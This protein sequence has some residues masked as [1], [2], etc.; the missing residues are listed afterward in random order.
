MTGFIR[1]I[2]FRYP[3]IALLNSETPVTALLVDV[4]RG[5]VTGRFNLRSG[6]IFGAPSGYSLPT[7]MEWVPMALDL[8][9]EF[10]VVCLHAAVVIVPLRPQVHN[11]NTLGLEEAGEDEE[12]KVMVFTDYD[13]PRALRDSSMR[14]KKAPRAKYRIRENKNV[15]YN[16][17]HKHL[18]EGHEAME[19]YELGP[20]SNEALEELQ[21]ALTPTRQIVASCFVAGKFPIPHVEL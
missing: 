13:H 20:P 5:Q 1:L 4:C 11:Q 6:R 9:K 12:K 15:R 21:H 14:L 16:G 18:V 17:D 8:N 2:T 3:T 10:I 19:R 7:P